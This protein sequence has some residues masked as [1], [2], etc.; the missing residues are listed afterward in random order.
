MPIP[1]VDTWV[2]NGPF[3]IVNDT[4]V[5]GGYQIVAD[6]AERLAIPIAKQKVGMRVFQ[7][8]TN[9]LYKLISTN[10]TL[11]N[12]DFEVDEAS[13]AP[14]VVTGCAV[15]NP[16][17]ANFE[18]AAGSFRTLN[19]KTITIPSTI[20]KALTS[21]GTFYF[22]WDTSAED[23]AFFGAS[24]MDANDMPFAV[25]QR[26][27]G[28]V[29][30][31]RDISMRWSGEQWTGW[32]TVGSVN[33]AGA[34]PSHFNSIAQCGQFISAFGG[35]RN[36][37][38]KIRVLGNANNGLTTALETCDLTAGG[39]VTV[40]SGSP[41]WQRELAVGDWVA[42]N[43]IQYQITSMVSDGEFNVDNPLGNTA[44]AG[45]L[46]RINSSSRY[47]DGFDT[48]MPG[49]N[50]TYLSGCVISGQSPDHVALS[51][52][53]IIWGGGNYVSYK[54]FFNLQ[55]IRIFV[56]NIDFEYDGQEDVSNTDV[57][58]LK[59]PAGGSVFENINVDCGNDSPFETLTC[60]VNLNPTSG[61]YGW[62]VVFE[63]CF[64]F[65]LNGDQTRFFNVRNST[66]GA[67]V[68]FRNG[69]LASQFGSTYPCAVVFY[70]ANPTTNFIFQNV[71]VD[72]FLTAFALTVS[73]TIPTTYPVKIYDSTIAGRGDH[74]KMGSVRS[75]A[76]PIIG[77]T[78]S[79]MERQADGSVRVT[80]GGF[81]PS[82]DIIGD[83]LTVSGMVNGANNGD[84]M[85][86]RRISTT[87]LVIWNPN[88]VDETGASGS[89]IWNY[90][91]DS[92]FVQ[93]NNTSL[94][95]GSNSLSLNARGAGGGG[96]VVTNSQELIPGANPIVG[97]SG[98][99]SAINDSLYG[100]IISD[101][102]LRE[103]G[104]RGI[105][106]NTASQVVWGL[107]TLP[108]AERVGV[109]SDWY[110]R[111]R[112]RVEAGA[113]VLPNGELAVI[114]SP[115]NFALRTGSGLGTPRS[116]IEDDGGIVSW[117]AI[118]AENNIYMFLRKRSDEL[119]A[120]V[121]FSSTPPQ[122]NGAFDS[123]TAGGIDTG[124]ADEDYGYLGQIQFW[125]IVVTDADP[126]VPSDAKMHS[127]VFRNFTV[128]YLGP[129]V[130]M[131]SPVNPT[132]GVVNVVDPGGGAA[133]VNSVADYSTAALVN[134][135]GTSFQKTSGQ[136]KTAC[137]IQA[138]IAF[139]AGLDNAER[140]EGIFGYRTLA[141]PFE[142]D[143]TGH[144]AGENHTAISAHVSGIIPLTGF[145]VSARG[146][147]RVTQ[148]TGTLFTPQFH[149][150]LMGVI[151]NVNNMQTFT[152]GYGLWP[153]I[154]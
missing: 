33:P 34:F 113:M 142:W 73:S 28:V 50:G 118:S 66:A 27:A 92:K 136:Y 75:I 35:D 126:G 87:V 62:S 101:A 47:N 32:F 127:D 120:G 110:H 141:M 111:V 56:D 139:K 55:N 46:E 124:Y 90:A 60:V 18:I 15:S 144:T 67:D 70:E 140:I 64:F 117:E 138:G 45:T 99:T 154:G 5:Y 38:N 98:P 41:R 58:W 151:E 148:I 53:E 36:A 42:I 84:F 54:P 121:T 43:G 130:R 68:V 82:T 48:G 112:V 69:R 22:A 29:T 51:R 105:F 16:S 79:A 149:N 109:A 10:A 145:N 100:G 6:E 77:G 14:G 61:D 80:I 89:L 8:D 95:A 44:V 31:F 21:D 135:G 115:E 94:Y 131:F 85:V 86:L 76:S 81:A 72:A 88:V 114:T 133:T 63:N 116:R 3:P 1:F 93:I 12:G 104:G 102:K 74:S 57:C 147:L 128:S 123:G 134:L 37:P 132:V 107:Q 129:S 152:H 122:L 146:F 150:T 83:V 24:A 71:K 49:F 59:D 9:T 153:Y 11:T 40:V 65:N 7:Q 39:N 2:P 78:V 91:V 17:G 26:T 4:D 52:P 13:A 143:N 106:T 137:A 20:S 119:T 108:Y 97:Y 23:M 19:G 96:L 125:D 30:Y 103:I 25:V